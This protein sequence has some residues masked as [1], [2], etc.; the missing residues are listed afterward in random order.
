MIFCGL[1]VTIISVAQIT[2]WAQQAP[3]QR[4]GPETPVD[5]PSFGTPAPALYP[6][7]DGFLKWRLLPSE[8]PYAAIDGKHL[9]QYIT[10]FVQIAY[11]YRDQGHQWWGR[12]QGTSADV[13][14]AQWMI[15]KFN[16]IGLSDVHNVPIDLPPQWFANSFQ[17]TAVG[18]GKTLNLPTAYPAYNSPGTPA[19]GS[20]L[21]AVYAG[22][23]TDADYHH[24]DVR[25]KAVVIF[26]V[27][28]P[29]QISSSAGLEDATQ[30][31]ESKGAAAVIEV[32]MLPG[33]IRTQLMGRQEVPTF[34]MGME[35]G[36]ALRDLIGMT[37][38]EKP[39]HLKIHLETQMV[40]NLKTS[41][42]FGTL[43]G[44]T[45]EKIYILA[46]RDSWFQ[47]AEDN[48]SGVAT[49]LGLAEYFAK[50]P[51]EK[52]R[53]T[54]IFMGTPGHHNDTGHPWGADYL[55]AHKGMLSKTAFIMNAEHTAAIGTHFQGE[56]I[57]ETNES[58][59]STWS[60]NGSPRLEDIIVKALREF[61][62]PTYAQPLPTAPGEI[63]TVFRVAP[64]FQLMNLTAP[65]FHSDNDVMVPYTGLENVTRAYANMIDEVNK[66]NLDDLQPAPTKD[67]SPRGQVE[68]E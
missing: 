34:T 60:I 46:H 59:A 28:L 42:V 38:T 52:R 39:V 68:R 16:K 48:G 56:A 20:D 61:G 33:N 51:R 25:G 6:L 40:P 31:A 36:Y 14:S 44:A 32:V 22:F 7:E 8:H 55:L 49:M 21:E 45:D 29:A 27:P 67:P 35:D 26:S 13:E 23:G 53:R 47:G 12:I 15:D 65:Y 18:G 63:S 17:V 5:R 2:G 37:S 64:S 66:A 41:I 50:T 1:V 10:E 24:L 30:R 11:R 3:A 4:P 54:I 9:E 62:V 58:D 43:P 19:E 57:D